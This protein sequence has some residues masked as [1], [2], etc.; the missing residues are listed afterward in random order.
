MKQNGL[1]I[2]ILAMTIWSLDSDHW[3]NS[4]WAVTV[5]TSTW[6][7]TAVDALGHT[8]IETHYGYTTDTRDTGGG[9]TST[10]TTTN[11][12]CFTGGAQ[13]GGGQWNL[14]NR[15]DPTQQKNSQ[16]DNQNN[17]NNGADQ[18][19]MLGMAAIAAGMAM[20]AAGMALLPNPP[21]TPIGVALIAA[22]MALIAAGMAAL[23][24]ASQ[25]NKNADK[26][27]YN[28]QNLDN[29]NPY[30]STIASPT[31]SSTDI[32]SSGLGGGNTSGIKIDPALTRSG[33]LDTI[34]HDMENKTGLN[35]E[36]MMKAIGGGA[37]P[38][39]VLANS[40]AL[41]GKPSSS[42][43][44]LQKMMD[45]TLAKGVPSGQEV[46]DKLG[47]TTGDLPGGS[48]GGASANRDI[49]SANIDNLFPG[50]PDKAGP[51]GG[52]NPNM[53]LSS[54]VQAALDKNG[55]T[56]R[57]IFEMVHTQYIKKTPLMFGVQ[58]QKDGTA[59]NPYMNLS[60]EKADI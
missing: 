25:M 34:F 31:S 58:K 4:A 18:S 37:N 36:D 47:L 41:A 50:A 22:G 17:N 28:G 2:L 10:G 42:S 35:R 38:L 39:D 55:I 23:A 15:T 1:W 56:G 29:L 30:A 5:K 52:D 13:Y 8:Y 54:E 19:S 43:A 26:S 12:N 53:K 49:A 27:G 11:T 20:V 21:T 57:T 32:G 9:G 60:G 59:P 3:I 46:M 16:N 40:P 33:K 51:S 44:N 48:G 6:T 14:C 7:T 45:D 24:A